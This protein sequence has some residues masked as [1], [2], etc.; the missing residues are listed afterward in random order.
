[1]PALL[2]QL[3]LLHTST[4]TSNANIL[5]QSIKGLGDLERSW[6]FFE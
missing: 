4:D 2:G 3:F 1:M 5:S 6:F